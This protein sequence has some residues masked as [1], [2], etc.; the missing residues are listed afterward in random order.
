MVDWIDLRKNQMKSEFANTG[1]YLYH[2]GDNKSA[3]T[4][5]V[6][7]MAR[8]G[9]T[10]VAAGLEKAGIPISLNGKI[11]N[12]K[13]DLDFHAAVKSSNSLE[14]YIEKR[15]S[16][17][18]GKTVGCK[19]PGA[20]NFLENFTNISNT[21]IVVLFRDPLAVA[22]RNAS[23]M[24]TP[25]DT[26][27]ETA[28]RN[29][30][31]IINA[32]RNSKHP[33]FLPCIILLSYEKLVTS[34]QETFQ[35]LYELCGLDKDIVT[36][37]SIK[38]SAAVCLNSA[39]YLKESNIIENYLVDSLTSTN[40]KGKICTQ[41]SVPEITLELGY[42]NSSKYLHKC[43]IDGRTALF[44]IDLRKVNLPDGTTE[45]SKLFLKIENT[46]HYL[47]K[48]GLAIAHDSIE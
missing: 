28:I 27:L 13:E 6:C 48:N 30:N 45:Q 4:I 46:E 18:K 19:Y 3:N 25:M 43:V 24:L 47:V 16:T 8:G 11:S 17:A 2:K 32:V 39:P 5:C 31:D 36:D 22:M 34:P 7:G 40:I 35:K 23:S 38:S 44:D 14:D 9:T 29:Y 37:L 12:V 42:G 1:I 26:S 41:F 33:N 20:Y 10:A 21:A 15:I